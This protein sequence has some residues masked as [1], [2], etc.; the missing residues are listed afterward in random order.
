MPAV[1]KLMAMKGPNGKRPCRAC[2]IEGVRTGL[3]D[4][5]GREEKTNY[6]PLSR[7]FVRNPARCPSYDPFNLP[8]RTHTDHIQQ[9]LDVEA[10]R[11][12]TDEEAQSRNTGI[13]GL[14]PLARLGSL[15][16]PTS[17][18]HDFMHLIFENVLPELLDLWTR[19]GRW[20]GFGTGHEDYLLPPKLW[21][22][23]GAACAASGDTIPA[24]FGCR[25]PNL[26]EKRH[27]KTSESMLLFATLL[28]PALLRDRFARP[29][30]YTHFLRLVKLINLC[31]GFEVT[32]DQVG[33]I[34]D[35]F[36]QW[37]QEFET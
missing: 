22:E 25:V 27:E 18:P 26:K 23:I 10:A 15:R 19:S 30:Y 3:L 16:F 7:G 8:R 2:K 35:G 33:E 5:S 12:D 31:M 14:S 13:N 9:A 37:V 29:R 1:A 11:N 17:F 4:R 24:A 21:G 34:R 20:K 32:F 28:G 6:V 36:A